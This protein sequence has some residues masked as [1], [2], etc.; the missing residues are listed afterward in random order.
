VKQI[1]GDGKLSPTEKQSV[2]RNSDPQIRA[3][4]QNS[5]NSIKNPEQHNN[6]L[7]YWASSWGRIEVV[8]WLLSYGADLN[9]VQDHGSTSLHV[10]SH[11]NHFDVC[12]LLVKHGAKKIR[13]PLNF[14]GESPILGLSNDQILELEKLEDLVN[15]LQL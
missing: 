10:A 14:G 2:L 15:S 4:I 13:T 5:I 9:V 7:L 8:K 12:K 6:S 1:L 3:F 11:R